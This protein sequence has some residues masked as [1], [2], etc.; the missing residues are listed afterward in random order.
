MITLSPAH[1]YRSDSSLRNR[2][3]H[4]QALSVDHRH[5]ISATHDRVDD[6]L[7]KGLRAIVSTV[8]NSTRSFA[9]GT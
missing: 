4:A 6:I 3:M 1:S 5:R 7:K 9:I 8:V 2:T